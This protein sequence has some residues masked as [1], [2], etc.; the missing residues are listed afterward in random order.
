MKKPRATFGEP[1]SESEYRVMRAVAK[2]W[3]QDVIAEQLQL[4][5][6]TVAQHLKHIYRKTGARDMV[7]VLVWMHYPMFLEGL[8]VKLDRPQ[9]R[10]NAR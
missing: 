5:R 4:A 8:Q 6:G 7:Q 2:G 9:S 1:V 3:Q 10:R